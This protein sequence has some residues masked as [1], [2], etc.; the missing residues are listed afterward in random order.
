MLAST[1]A[2]IKSGMAP[3]TNF[4]PFLSVSVEVFIFQSVEGRP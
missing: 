3:K 1:G 2:K 4:N